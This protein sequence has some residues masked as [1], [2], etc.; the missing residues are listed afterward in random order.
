MKTTQIQPILALALLFVVTTATVSEAAPTGTA[1]TYQGRLIDGN[2]V[3]DG[4]YDF[5]FGLYDSASD[6][7]Q[8]ADDVNV[9]D[10]DVIDGY[11]TVALDFGSSVFDGDARW[12]DIGVRAGDM[13]DPNAYIPL[14]PRQEVTPTPYALQTRGIFVDESGKVGLGTTSPQYKLHIVDSNDNPVIWAQQ[15]GDGPALIIEHSGPSDAMGIINSGNP[16]YALWIVQQGDNPALVISNDTLPGAEMMVVTNSGSVGIGTNTPSATLDVNGHINS[17]ES[18][19]LDG[20]TVLSNTGTANT[21]VGD[22]AGAS[23]A[24]GTYNT[25]IGHSALESTDTGICNSAVGAYALHSNSSGGHNS[26]VGYR[27]LYYNTGAINSAFGSFALNKNITGS[28]NTAMGYFALYRNTAGSMNTAVGAAALELNTTGGQN[29]ALGGQAGYS[30]QGNG[31]VLLGYRAGYY[32]TGS[33]KLYIA[34]SDT[35]EPLIYGEFDN[36]RV[37]IDT[38]T[39]E[40]TLDVDG[41]LAVQNGPSIDEISTDG[42]LADDSDL[43]VP[44]EKA[45]KTYVDSQVGSVNVGVVPIGGVTAWMKS[46]PNTPSLSLSD[47]WVECNGQTLSDSYSLYNGQVIP[48]LNG[49]LGTQRFLRGATASGGTGGSEDH[50]H[51]Q[52][53]STGYVSNVLSGWKPA[54]TGAQTAATETLPSYYEVVWIMRVK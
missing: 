19:K 39:P 49:S 24:T 9:P 1:F 20:Y 10:V 25:A 52:T 2:D 33:D 43:A 38:N 32:E 14:S 18:Y 34:N 28:T 41:T 48:D 27:A 30:N 12:L 50:T 26:A 36:R 47:E 46:Y 7:N 4:V 29:T 16:G 53:N 8:V 5:N 21:W 13:N 6:G 17:S 15:T 23:V 37:G 40:A 3:A 22:N 42:T 35:N 51:T 45:V 54:L 31:N 11:F 44:T